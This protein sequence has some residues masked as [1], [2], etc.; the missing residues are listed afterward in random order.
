MSY[1]Y[2]IDSFTWFEYHSGSEK[3]LKIREVIETE[4]IAT[5]II[6]IAELSDKFHR[7]DVDFE[8][9]LLFIRSR[10]AILPITV[11]IAVQAG[12]LK[13]KMRRKAKDFGLADAIILQTALENDAQLISGDSDFRHAPN[14]MLI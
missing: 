3:G 8:K 6:T 5:S 11:S 10:S 7:E 2:V 12:Q 13:K 4:N 14:T 9:L 1:K